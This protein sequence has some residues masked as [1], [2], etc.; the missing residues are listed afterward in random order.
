ML[1]NSQLPPHLGSVEEDSRVSSPQGEPGVG[2]GG[3][4]GGGYKNNA[5]YSND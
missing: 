1:N 2:V 4:G 3:L 5:I